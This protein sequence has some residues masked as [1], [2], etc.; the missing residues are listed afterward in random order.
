ME[1]V[2]RA[3]VI[4]W[5]LWVLLRATGKRELAEITPFELITLLVLGDIVQQGVTGEDMSVTGAGLAAGT[6]VLWTLVLAYASFR[7]PHIKNALESPPSIVVRDGRIVPE[8][9][10]IQRL[11]VGDVM[12]AARSQG[13]ADLSSVRFGILEPD[14]RFSFL[15]DTEPATPHPAEERPEV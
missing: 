8:M 15:T 11:V 13:I 10:R 4:F 14:G 1:I 3:T 12:E 7:S 9:L 5:V 2:I 6:I